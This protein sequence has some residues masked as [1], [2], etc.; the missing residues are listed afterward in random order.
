LISYWL[1]AETAYRCRHQIIF[2]FMRQ[3]I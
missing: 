2:L 1:T 3:L